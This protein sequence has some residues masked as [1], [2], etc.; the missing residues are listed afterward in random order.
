MTCLVWRR[1]R[2][3][4]ASR[5]ML[6]PASHGRGSCTAAPATACSRGAGSCN[7]GSAAALAAAG[8]C[9]RGASSCNRGSAAASAAAPAAAGRCSRGAG[10]CNRGSVTGRG[11]W[12]AAEGRAAVAAVAGRH[13]AR[14]R[15][16]QIGVG[17]GMGVGVGVGERVWVDGREGRGKGR[18]GGGKG[19]EVEGRGGEGMGGEW[20]GGEWSL[21]HP[22]PVSGQMY[23]R[24]H[25]GG[26]DETHCVLARPAGDA[27]EDADT[28][29]TRAARCADT[30]RTRAASNDV[31]CIACVRPGHACDGRMG[32]SSFM[33]VR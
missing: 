1:R 31:S 33:L 23:V 20:R 29:R 18:E 16:G 21:V 8:R 6:Y 26:S 4:Y 27:K 19:R 12:C 22:W 3:S 10:R 14:H 28:G 15:L 17:V 5:V 30:G 2:L 32:A 9:S 25:N 24:S 13:V 7:R 11:S